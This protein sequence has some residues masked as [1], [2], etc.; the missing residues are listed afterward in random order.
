MYLIKY[1]L[2]VVC[3]VLATAIENDKTWPK[4][5]LF[6]SKQT[7]FANDKIPYYFGDYE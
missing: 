3:V 1:Y 7:I 5:L 6:S 4:K 2:N